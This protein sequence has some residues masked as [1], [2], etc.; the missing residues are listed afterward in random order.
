MTFNINSDEGEVI[1]YFEWKTIGKEVI[2]KESTETVTATVKE[3]VK[4]SL[5][6]L[7]REFEEELTKYLCHLFN[8]SHQFLKIFINSL[9]TLYVNTKMRSSQFILVLLKSRF[10]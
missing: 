2:T 5:E 9:K 6:V 7:V 4:T 8:I 10:R 1:E 3:K